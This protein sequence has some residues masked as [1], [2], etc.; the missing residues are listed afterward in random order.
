M[1][2]ESQIRKF[3][4]DLKATWAPHWHLLVPTIR[5]SIVDAHV[6]GLVCGLDRETIPVAE[7]DRLRK[8][9]HEGMGTEGV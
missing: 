7:I 1:W 5:A 4:R 3:V 2:N 6:L 9:L 8:A